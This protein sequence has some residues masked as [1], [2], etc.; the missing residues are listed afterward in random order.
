MESFGIYDKVWVTG[1]HTATNITFNQKV[2]IEN[3]EIEAEKYAF[4]TI[5]Q[6]NGAWR[7]ILSPWRDESE[8]SN[9]N[10][11]TDG[12]NEED[13]VLEWQITPNWFMLHTERLT[14]KIT[15]TDQDNIKKIWMYWENLSISF[16]V[17]FIQ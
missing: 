17:H 12:Y 2:K 9:A 16:E 5:P 14:Y 3:Q 11:L 8:N 6:E 15:D 13:K 1:A 10:H 7:L 4:F